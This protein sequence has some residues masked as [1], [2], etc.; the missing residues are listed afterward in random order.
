MRRVAVK[1]G[2][3]GDKNQADHHEAAADEGSIE[4]IK[5][6]PTETLNGA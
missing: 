5:K 6:E 3:K 2:S 4:N 1:V